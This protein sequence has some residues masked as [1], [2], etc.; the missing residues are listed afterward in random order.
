MRTIVIGKAE[1]I[2]APGWRGAWTALAMFTLAAIAVLALTAPAR[3]NTISAS[4]YGSLG[5]QGRRHRGRLGIGL[6]RRR[7]QRCGGRGRW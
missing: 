3:A 2:Q 7:P 4:T 5:G 6:Q 1:S